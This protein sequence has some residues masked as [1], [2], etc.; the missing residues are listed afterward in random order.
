VTPLTRA[1]LVANARV[2]GARDAIVTTLKTL[3]VDIEVKTHLGKLDISDVLQKS[4][5]NPPTIAVAATR[6]KP[7]GRLSG[8]DDFVVDF[9]AYVV[10]E[11]LLIGGRRVGRDEMALAICE[12]LLLSLTDDDFS[13][14]NVEDVGPPEDA[15]AKP[16]F[17]IKSVA[18]GVV[19]YA[20]TWKQTLF[21]VAPANFFTGGDA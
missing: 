5:F 20:V 18:Q 14:W 7:D 9:T 11:D 2:K 21:D 1:D 10:T 15:E 17:T 16:L 4:I 12:G 19:Y 13:R 6:T 8:A 3:F